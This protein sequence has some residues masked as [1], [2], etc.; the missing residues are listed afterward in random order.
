MKMQNYNDYFADVTVCPVTGCNTKV[1]PR[2]PFVPLLVANRQ[3]ID[4]DFQ[5]YES[6]VILRGF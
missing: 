4:E 3:K 1:S 2:A 6:V 5:I